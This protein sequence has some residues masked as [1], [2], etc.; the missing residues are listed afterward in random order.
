MFN[1]YKQFFFHA[2]AVMVTTL[3]HFELGTLMF[4]VLGS[5][6]SNLSSMCKNVKTC[7]KHL[8]RGWFAQVLVVFF[9]VFLR[10]TFFK[11]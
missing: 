1:R 8:S 3:L 2:K 7:L 11:L 5:K 6:F 4:Q 10:K 9:F